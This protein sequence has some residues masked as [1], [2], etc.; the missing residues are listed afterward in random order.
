M[1]NITTIESMADRKARR[2]TEVAAAFQNLLAR[3]E[4]K[5]LL[6][7]VPATEPPELLETLLK[8]AF[9]AGCLHGEGAIAGEMIGALLKGMDKRDGERD[10]RGY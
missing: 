3:N 4:V 6:S 7:M 9:E 8:S 2:D 10:R 1:S 5:L